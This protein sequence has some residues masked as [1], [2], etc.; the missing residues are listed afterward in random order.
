MF[1]LSQAEKSAPTLWMPSAPVRQIHRKTSQGASS[2]GQS[3]KEGYSKVPNK[4]ANKV[5]NKGQR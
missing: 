1:D 2:K 3:I 4:V 5:A